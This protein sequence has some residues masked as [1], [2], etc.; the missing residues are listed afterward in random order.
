M[1]PQLIDQ[2]HNYTLY[3]HLFPL[4]YIHSNVFPISNSFLTTVAMHKD[5]GVQ[6]DGAGEH[7]GRVHA[8][9]FRI[10]IDELVHF[11]I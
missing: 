11:S 8:Y 7:L 5:K 9:L 2:R 3:F 6:T 4:Q 10:Q 1:I